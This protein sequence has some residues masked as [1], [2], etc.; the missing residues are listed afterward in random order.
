MID[1]AHQAPSSMRL[2]GGLRVRGEF[3]KRSEPGKPLVTVVT[4][5]RNGGHLLER[6]IQSVLEQSY[7]NIEYIII[8]GASTDGT[9][10]T[11]R[12]YEHSL[13][14]WIS[15]PDKGL[16]DA[17]NKGAGLSSGDWV[18]FMNA[19]DVFYRPDS[20]QT[21][22][23]GKDDH[24]DLVYGHCQM[25]FDQ[26]FSVIWK[27]KKV[28]DL[29]KGM[30]CRHQS[31]FTKTSVFK[32]ISFDL[33][34]KIGADFAFIFSC[35]QYG[36]RF[37]NLDLVVASVALGGLSDVNIVLAMQENL[38]AV[39]QFSATMKVKLYYSWVIALTYMKLH[40]K[41]IMPGWVLR[42]VRTSKYR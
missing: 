20:V 4:V 11:I 39:M 34:F 14:Y 19:G 9:I 5:V 16:Y 15:E 10:D 31:L 7:D 40:I 12:N 41:K 35:Y 23:N 38:R 8:D 42:K 26:K 3:Y 21:V 2:E 18:N 33:Q 28:T 6:T 27:T 36:Y 25:I 22:M 29:W 30:I 17:M 32:K 37:H 13:A 1:V 24:A